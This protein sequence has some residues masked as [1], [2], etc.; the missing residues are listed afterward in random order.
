MTERPLVWA[1][2]QY[3]S[4]AG[5][6]DRVEIAVDV[7]VS[8]KRMS[9]ARV[10][11]RVGEREILAVQ[12]ALGERDDPRFQQFTGMPELPP[13]DSV[14]S[15]PSE[16][17]GDPLTP[18]PRLPAPD[19]GPRGRGR[20]PLPDVDARRR[21]HGDQRGLLAVFADHL[22][23]ALPETRGASSLDNTLRIRALRPTRWCLLDTR[24]HASRTESSTARCSSTRRTGP[25]LAT[26]SQSGTLPQA[27]SI[28]AAERPGTPRPQSR[29]ML[30]PPLEPPLPFRRKR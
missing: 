20:G 6:G 16:F 30:P 14:P 8:G 27:P 15:S 11:A 3:L 2:A 23:G 19:R 7:P 5:P 12:A 25:S 4:F 21:R 1:T 18:R 9:Q 24:I 10:S 13:P 26:A 28:G 22:P 17:P 29:S